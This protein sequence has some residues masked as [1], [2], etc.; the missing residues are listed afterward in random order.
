MGDPAFADESLIPDH[1]DIGLSNPE[2]KCIGGWYKPVPGRYMLMHDNL[3]DLT[4]LGYL[5]RNTFGGG[6]DEAPI[7]GTGLN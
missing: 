3:F 6:A 4:H 2:Y 5:H 1:F 7:L